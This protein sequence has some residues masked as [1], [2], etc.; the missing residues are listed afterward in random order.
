MSVILNP[1]LSFNNTA[2]AAMELYQSIFGGELAISTFGDMGMAENPADT[3]RVMHA[4]L[5]GD[6]GLVLMASDNATEAELVS[7]T[8]FSISLSGDDDALLRGYWAK[9]TASGDVVV[10]LETAPWG[11]S[12]GM[13]KDAF[14]I[15]WMVN[16]TAAGA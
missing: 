7:G 6:K 13:C 4:M 16:I 14:G 2:R 10:P 5:T 8:D 9:L 3:D 12:F 15:T 1:Y 11:D